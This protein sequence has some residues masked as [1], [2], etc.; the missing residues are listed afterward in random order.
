M[1]KILLFAAMP[2]ALLFSCAPPPGQTLSKQTSSPVGIWR[3]TYTVDQ[4][5]ILPPPYAFFIKSDGTLITQGNGADGN[6]YYSQGKW[7]L[8]RDTL[9][10]VYYTIN[11]PHPMTTQ[12]AKFYFDKK[13]GNLKSGK[14]WDVKNGSDYTGEFLGMTKDQ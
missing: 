4:L 9:R 13:K 10:C 7:K 1:K 3:G 12:A 8:D 6:T 5:D 11:A 14:W 2:F